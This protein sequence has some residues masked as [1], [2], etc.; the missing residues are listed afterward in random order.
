MAENVT[1][2]TTIGG[3]AIDGCL[4]GYTDP[5]CDGWYDNPYPGT[6]AWPQLREFAIA[7]EVEHYGRDLVKRAAANVKA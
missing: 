1:T 5:R 4:P 2:A 6:W 3:M 7:R